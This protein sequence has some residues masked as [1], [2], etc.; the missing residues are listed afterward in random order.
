[1]EE[2]IKY[3]F[4]AQTA[5]E[6]EQSCTISTQLKKLE[7]LN[8]LRNPFVVPQQSSPPRKPVI[9]RL[10]DT[11]FFCLFFALCLKLY[12]WIS[13]ILL[14]I[15]INQ[16]VLLS[17]IS[18]NPLQ[19]SCLENPHGQRS[20]GDYSPWGRTVGHNWVAKHKQYFTRQ[21]HHSIFIYPTADGCLG[22]FLPMD[23]TNYAFMNI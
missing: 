20:M 11:D 9:L 21:R 3:T 23:I 16:F 6:T 5:L 18:C 1:M 17:S 8:S 14:Y 4:R 2:D 12:L 7:V 10:K 15:V 19:Y 22:N 13:I